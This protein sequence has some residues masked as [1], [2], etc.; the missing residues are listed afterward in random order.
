MVKPKWIV[1]ACVKCFYTALQLTL[2]CVAPNFGPHLNASQC[3]FSEGQS[4]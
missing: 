3:L 1:Q 2:E 4:Q